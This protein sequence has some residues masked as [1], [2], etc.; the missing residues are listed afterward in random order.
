GGNSVISNVRV[1]LNQKV[2]GI[3]RCS[4]GIVACVISGRNFVSLGDSEFEG[5]SSIS[6]VQIDV[7]Q[8][9][10]R[11]TE[12]K[13]NPFDQTCVRDGSNQVS[14][15]DSFLGNSTLSKI[16]ANRDQKVTGNAI[17]D[18]SFVCSDVGD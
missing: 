12:C 6:D 5:N 18:D 9:F 14:V 11:I 10:D 16:N 15:G 1:D 4:D 7:D 2:N 17:C 8:E 13:N 3:T